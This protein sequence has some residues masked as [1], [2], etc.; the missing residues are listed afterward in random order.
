MKKR[1]FYQVHGI[2]PNTPRGLVSDFHKAGW[3]RRELARRLGVN[4]FYINQLFNDGIEPTDGTENG[5]AIRVKLHLPKKKRKAREKPPHP[6]PLTLEWWDELRKRAVRAMAK[7]TRL[8][9]KRRQL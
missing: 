7:R 8:S 6:D 5:Q 3:N 1:D 9:M 4:V 2:H